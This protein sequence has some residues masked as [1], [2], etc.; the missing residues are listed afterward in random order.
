MPTSRFILDVTETALLKRKTGIQRVVTELFKS[1]RA[2][3]DFECLYAVVDPSLKGGLLILPEWPKRIDILFHARSPLALI[4]LLVQ[5]LSVSPSL[6]KLLR[7][8]GKEQ[9]AYEFFRTHIVAKE[10]VDVKGFRF[11]PTDIYVIAD[12]AW[13]Y[14]RSLSALQA[15]RNAGARSVLYVHDFLPISNPEWFPKSG[16][17]QFRQGIN[18]ILKQVTHVAFSTSFVS[19]EYRRFVE[20][21]DLPNPILP[22]IKLPLGALGFTQI[23]SKKSAAK[24]GEWKEPFGLMVGSIEPRKGHDFLLRYVEQV[25]DAFHIVVVGKFGWADAEILR[26]MQAESKRGRITYFSS[27]NDSFLGKLVERAKFGLVLSRGEGYGLPIFEFLASG[28][29]VVATDLPVFRE[30]APIGPRYIPYGDVQALH[31]AI[32]TEVASP[33]VLEKFEGILTWQEAG[34]MW[35]RRLDEIH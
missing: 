1:W 17:I 34:E 15:V 5:M 6:R 27:V 28:L 16:S 29:S 23:E 25:P 8:L 14:D 18:S 21:G 10:T 19:H 31:E 35:L 12:A 3:R 11:L 32:K 4:R 9:K 13:T 26:R 22:M 2:Q 7:W 24:I 30:I 33:F 20:S